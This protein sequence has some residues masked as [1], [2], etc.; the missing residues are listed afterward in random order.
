MKTMLALAMLSV[1]FLLGMA[2]HVPAIPTQAPTETIVVIGDAQK[3]AKLIHDALFFL[4]HAELINIPSYEFKDV[5]SKVETPSYN[6]FK[7][8]VDEDIGNVGQ[9][10]ITDEDLTQDI[11][12]KPLPCPTLTLDAPINAASL[13]I[14]HISSLL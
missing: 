4:E 13:A 14:S 7:P 6:Q 3:S 1:G 2:H 12:V 8:R 11:S 9:P 5:P 10:G